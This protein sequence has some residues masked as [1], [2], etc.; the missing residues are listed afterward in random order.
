MNKSIWFEGI[1]DIECNIEN[2]KQS[3]DT[4][5][6]LFV[7]VVRLTPGITSAEIIEKANKSITIKT[8]EGIMKRTNI[9]TTINDESVILEFDEEYQV[10]QKIQVNTH[11]FHEFTVIGN[12]IKHRIILSDV[13]APG[14]LGF[15]YRNFGKSNIGNSILNSYRDYFM[16]TK[17]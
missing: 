6:E 15:F 13:K 1:N 9:S 11:Y 7:N 12:N 5:N 2:I 3:I 16:M 14:F 4:Y 8:N 10:G 17:K